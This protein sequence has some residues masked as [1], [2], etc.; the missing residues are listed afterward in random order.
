M[1]LPCAYRYTLEPPT[2]V[3]SR[4]QVNSRL[5]SD[6]AMRSARY[7]VK[8]ADEM[9]LPTIKK[10]GHEQTE[11]GN[12]KLAG[13]IG[14]WGRANKRQEARVALQW[15]LEDSQRRVAAAKQAKGMLQ[16]DLSRD[17]A[18]ANSNVQQWEMCTQAGVKFWM[19]R[20][21]GEAATESPYAVKK[22]TDK[23]IKDMVRR[24]TAREA[25]LHTPAVE[26]QLVAQSDGAQGTGSLV[27]D[28]RPY[29]ELLRMLDGSGSGDLN[30]GP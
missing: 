21:T 19:N 17:Q 1:T 26:P 29:S 28:T 13:I 22:A 4:S 6:P 2:W 9:K 7:V 16:G 15:D 11:F 30:V 18:A 20:E 24:K 25:A 23:L 5:L 3:Q 10:T 8:P 12:G 14:L 27:Y